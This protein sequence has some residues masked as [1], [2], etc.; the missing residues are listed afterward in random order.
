M[1]ASDFNY[2]ID[3]KTLDELQKEKEIDFIYKANNL[4]DGFLTNFYK[5]SLQN[6]NYFCQEI[7]EYNTEIEFNKLLEAWK[8][9]KSKFSALRVRFFWQKKN[10][11]IID[12]Y[13]DDEKFFSFIE[14]DHIPDEDNKER[15]I[16][17]IQEE[18]R[19]NMFNL[20]DGNL[21]RVIL[22]KKQ[23]DNYILVISFHHSIIDGW[24]FSIILNF[25]NETYLKI[26]KKN[27]NH[28]FNE[29]KVTDFNNVQSYLQSP[30]NKN[31]NYWKEKLK[32]IEEKI[33]LKILK[34]KSRIKENE[35]GI[36]IFI[37]EFFD[38]KDEKYFKILS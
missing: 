32:E 2:I 5:D 34:N 15:I 37:N 20:K 7:Y 3:Q 33:D 10:I 35:N 24:S 17:K 16:K 4:F 30:L 19:L 31:Y 1:T 8:I 26:S 29:N 14:L 28:S 22:I 38:I 11:Q 6:D 13:Q 23:K 36:D 25:A 18:D 27:Q 21:F 9:T 12:K